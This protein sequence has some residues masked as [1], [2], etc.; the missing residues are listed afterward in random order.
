MNNF[1]GVFDSA[2]SI[3]NLA[4]TM[5]E[6]I[7]PM[8]ET[9]A[10]S[11]AFQTFNST[12]LIAAS[13]MIGFHVLLGIV[14][15]AQEGQVLGKQWHQIWAPVRAVLGIGSL[16]PVF[17]GFCMAQLAV[18]QVA[19]WGIDLGDKVWST[20]AK[21]IAQVGHIT[22]PNLQTSDDIIHDLVKMELCRLK[23]V[24]LDEGIQ[25]GG[26]TNSPFSKEI[27]YPII[28]S[29]TK[30]NVTDIQSTQYNV[31]AKLH[32]FDNGI[33][34]KVSIRVGI[35]QD[36]KGYYTVAETSKIQEK[37]IEVINNLL[38][39]IEGV[40]QSILIAQKGY[41]SMPSNAF[42]KQ[43]KSKYD[44][45]MVEI[46][47][48]LS[49]ETQTKSKYHFAQQA[50][51][52]GWMSAGMWYLTVS[53]IVGDITASASTKPTTTTPDLSILVDQK[54]TYYRPLSKSL[55]G[56]ETWWRS[57]NDLA[58]VGNYS[59]LEA[60]RNE[61]ADT[62][63]MSKALEF[64]EFGKLE[65]IYEWA[66]IDTT[67]PVGSMANFGH[68]VIVLAEGL[69]AGG[70][71]AGM[72]AGNLA[73]ATVGGLGGLMFILPVLWFLVGAI[74]IVGILHALILP[75]LP[76]ITMLTASLAYVVLVLEAL[77]AG[78]IWAFVHCRLDGQNMIDQPQKTGYQ[79]L[80]SLFLRPS[81]IIF[82]L[83]FGMA[84]LGVVYGFI[85]ETF[86]YAVRG[87]TAGFFAGPVVL[88]VML[89]LLSYLH[90]FVVV[91]CM[92][93]ATTFP[94]RITRWFGA[95]PDSLGEQEDNKQINAVVTNSMQ[96]A[97]HKIS[98]RG[99]KN[100]GPK[101]PEKAEE[102]AVSLSAP[103]DEGAKE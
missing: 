90:W 6:A 25:I 38:P 18:M 60:G 39:E 42:I 96:S 27:D 59:N 63:I 54:H 57:E 13:F 36:E 3:N 33:C 58:L 22:T 15:T 92:L 64:L 80:F 53:N 52:S 61:P 23:A 5:L 94:D 70:I 45:A 32:N 34:G 50:E 73:S 55:S 9:T 103:K 72:L 19:L 95:T 4:V 97:S 29:Q 68:N 87:S 89:C 30:R 16:A 56:F 31:S 71:L 11:G 24:E 79:I 69:T 66:K 98:P 26:I 88:V 77:I 65:K 83:I 75:M 10:L 82:G 76:Y 8:N 44:S 86:Y 74:W 99:P 40:A 102:N 35:L 62:G 28:P 43:I 78:P 17:N 7:V 100:S 84:I 46:A 81:L 67:N 1:G 47:N 12:I 41:S 49:S 21:D 37:Q 85:N 20:F 2:S 48:K 14:N 51:K 93:L 91:K 101:A